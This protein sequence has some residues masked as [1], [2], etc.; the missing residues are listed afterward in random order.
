[1][2]AVKV[3]SILLM[4]FLVSFLAGFSPNSIKH[5][6]MTNLVAVAGAGFLMGVALL[7]VLPESVKALVDS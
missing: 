1:M 7:I 6:K 4:S 2:S 5:P 3:L